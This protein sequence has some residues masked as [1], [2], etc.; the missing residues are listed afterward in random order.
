MEQS[1]IAVLARIDG[2]VHV[3]RCRHSTIALQS[4]QL[5]LHE[6][7]DLQ[8]RVAVSAGAILE[9]CTGITFVTSSPLLFD[10]KDF[11]WLRSRV[12]SPNYTVEISDKEVD[13]EAV[14]VN[15]FE[16]SEKSE[17]DYAHMHEVNLNECSAV[18]PFGTPDN[19]S[20]EDEL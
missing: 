1:T 10:V 13:A 6:S 9:E 5:R 17:K 19:E 7:S 4:Q 2:A 8:C 11:D 15:A 14:V 12:P 3:T 16:T 20:D 18:T